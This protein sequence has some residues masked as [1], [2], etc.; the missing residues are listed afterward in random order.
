MQPDASYAR[1][2]EQ[3]LPRAVVRLKDSNGRYYLTP[4]ALGSAADPRPWGAPVVLTTQ[5][6][7]GTALLGSFSDSVVAYVRNG[8]RVETSGMGETQ[9]KNNTT[10][11]RAEARLVLTVPRPAGLVKVTG[12]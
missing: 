4:D 10:L 1:P 6:T 2:V 9:F 11:V 8:I 5:M 3:R 12:L 7:A